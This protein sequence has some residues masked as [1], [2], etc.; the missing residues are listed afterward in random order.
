M[1]IKITRPDALGIYPRKRLFRRL[2]AE[3]ERPIVWVSGPPGCGKTALVSSYL[4]ERRIPCLW[5]RVEK[6]DADLGAFFHYLGLAAK[7]AAPKRKKP[8]PRFDPKSL[9]EISRFAGRYFEELCDRMKV[10]SVLVFDNFERLA[11]RS[12]FVEAIREGFSSLP[13]GVNAIVLSRIGPP[14]VFS[15][16]WAGDRIGVLGWKDLRLTFEEIEGVVGSCGRRTMSGETIRYLQSRSDGWAAGV[17]L[18]MARA[19]MDGIEPQRLSRRAPEEIFDYFADELFGRMGRRTRRFLI[20]TAFLPTLTGSMARRISGYANASRILS[21][22][23][24]RNYFVETVPGDDPSFRY[25]NLFRDFL[26]SRASLEFPAAELSR[27]RKTASAIL[28]ESGRIEEAASLLREDQGWDDL[29]RL[30]RVHAGRLVRQGMGHTLLEWMEGLPKATVRK[31]PW[32]LYWTGVCRLPFAPAESRVLF[33]DAFR[34]F[35]REGDAEGEFLSWAGVVDAIVYGPEGLRPLD[36]RFAALED[37][38]RDHMS[39]PSPGVE[40]RVTCAAVKA[41]ALRRPQSVDIDTWSERATALARSTEDMELR[42]SLLMK[43]AL[44]CYHGGDLQA[45]G[46][47][48]DTLRGISRNPEIAPLSRLELFWLEA[49]HAN[50]TGDHHRCRKVVEEGL[51]L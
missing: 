12:S 27:I 50:I 45:F 40:A 35:R 30:I 20:R 11:A 15:R 25:H 51:A 13:R 17:V 1:N 39:F 21:W 33:E 10:P 43:V 38:L 19:G 37:L 32:L 34:G 36:P 26:L 31:T 28:E 22:L 6:G 47:H 16:K 48:L 7:H 29:A 14:S 8:L 18:L 42:F 5:Y 4:A 24:Y 2:D 44:C 46:F 23:S 41:L 3:R 9:P 49:A